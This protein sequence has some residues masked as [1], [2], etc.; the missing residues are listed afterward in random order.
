MQYDDVIAY[1][2]THAN[3]DNVKGMA[4]FGI[5]PE[6]NLGLS[7]NTLRSFAKNI[8]KNHALA[9]ELW[10]SGIHDARLLAVL[11][12]NPIKVTSKQMN[13]WA[14]NFNSWDICDQACTSL[15]DQTTFAWKKVFEWAR[16]DE[17]FVRRAAFS[18]IAGLAV[19]DK[20][21]SDTEFENV[22]PLITKHAVDER[23]YV[24]KA[25]N[26]ALRNI[27]KRNIYLNKKTIRLSEEILK[28]SSKSARWIAHD[29]LRELQS[30]KVQMRLAKKK[31]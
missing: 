15:F 26:W 11:I 23:N 6:N 20:T 30:D 25:V 1:L 22:F 24:K 28:I 19:H 14:K 21:A 27:G 12:E 29:A 18:L 17:E 10:D 5:N 7:V 2:K 16:R 4:R 9:L 31:H 13:A 8:G 3:P